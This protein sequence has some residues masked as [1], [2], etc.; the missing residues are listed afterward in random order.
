M[1]KGLEQGGNRS[2]SCL[3]QGFSSGLVNCELCNSRASL[4][5]QADDAYLCKKC[6]KWV[7]QANF[8]ALR[9]IRCF[10]CSTCQSLTQRYLIGAS[11]EVMLPTM[12]T[13]SETSHCNSD[14]ETHLSTTLK[15]P[16]LFL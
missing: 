15:T 8:L 11:H 13:S 2:S 3:K 12:V 6:D 10:L 16:F 1:C 4:Y 14:M 9:H 7:H 5:C